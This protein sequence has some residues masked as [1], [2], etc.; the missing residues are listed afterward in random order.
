M[1]KG[2]KLLAVL[3]SLCIAAAM[4]PTAAFAAETAEKTDDIV[5]LHTNDVHCSVD[6]SIGYAGLAAY[7]ADKL[8]QTDYVA[9]VD[10]GDAVQGGTV[11]ALSKG[12]YI[13]DI[14]NKVGYDVAAPGNHEFDFGMDKFLALAAKSSAEYVSANFVD[15]KGETVFNPYVIKTY[16]DKKVAFVGVSTPESYTKS[17]PAYFQDENGNDI[18]GFCGGNDGKDLYSA[19]QKAVD[20]AKAEGADYVIA[21]AHLGID[22]ESSPWTSKEVI[23]NT[24]GIDVMIDGH[25]HSTITDTI[26]TAKDGKGV[27]LTQTGTGLEAI[28]EIVITADG[29]ITSSLVTDYTAKDAGV[30]AAV[31]EIKDKISAITTKVIG[32]SEVTLNDYDADGNRLVRKQETTVGNYCADAYRAVTGAE[33]GL[34]QGGGVRAPI[35]KGTVTYGDLVEVNPWGNFLGVIEATGQQ[36]LDALEHGARSNPG[37]VGGFLQVSGL[38]Y[39]IDTTIPSTV[40]TNEKGEFVEVSGARRVKDVKVGGAAIDPEKTYTVASTLYILTQE[41]DGFTMFKGAKEV[42]KE[43]I[44]DSDALIQYMQKDLNGKIGKQYAKTEGRIGIIKAYNSNDVEEAIE[45]AGKEAVKA[46][47]AAIARTTKI[48][49]AKASAKTKKITVKISGNS[50]ADGFYYRVYNAKGKRV[51]YLSK[52]GESFSSRKLS[53][54]KF[55]VKVTPYTYVAGEKVYGKAVSKKVTV[56]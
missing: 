15:A 37:E 34:V 42:T 48:T 12:E 14:M 4:M 27:I 23:A 28:G 25:S 18:Y 5:I 6:D 35:K 52:T 29:K 1:K 39:D 21:L 32:T 10:A 26:V 46:Y 50:K 53:K 22:E 49:S 9:L 7:K 24:S 43:S 19:V 16:G 45:N 44:I 3:L 36:I 54:G 8:K 38:S 2:R 56:K 47:K 31:N 13:I 11:G 17:T 30:E 20:A 40:V 55:T 41:G 33:I 51:S